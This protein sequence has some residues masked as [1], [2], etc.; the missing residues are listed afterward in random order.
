M[1]TEQLIIPKRE[2]DLLMNHLKL[3]T[4]LSDFNKKKLNNELKKA[5]IVK[6]E[7]LPDNVIVIDSLVTIQDVKSGQ[8]FSFHLVTP[9]EANM[10][11]HKLSVLAP[12]GIALLGYTTDAV[13]DW[14]MPD[15]V[16]QFRIKKVTRHEK[17]N[18]VEQP[19]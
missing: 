6:K 19:Q 1:E 14:E 8:E 18:E 3:S 5:K 4:N 16:K 17:D 12:I 10:K 2:Y 7:V 15:G 13:V 11:K 9:E